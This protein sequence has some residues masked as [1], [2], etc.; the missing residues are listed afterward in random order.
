M[1]NKTKNQYYNRVIV[2]SRPA[3]DAETADPTSGVMKKW[4]VKNLM[5]FAA[6]L[7]RTFPRWCAMH[8]YEKDTRVWL[9]T[10]TQYKRPDQKVLK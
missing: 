5:S 8:V 2:K 10:Y 7:D 9:R 4:R 1:A 3:S 6:F